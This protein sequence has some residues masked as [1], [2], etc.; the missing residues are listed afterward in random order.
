MTGALVSVFLSGC[1]GGQPAGEG[2]DEAPVNPSDGEGAS[3]KVS[4]CGHVDASGLNGGTVTAFNEQ[5]PEVEAQYVEIGAN[6]DQSRTQQVQRLEAQSTECDVFLMDVT[7]V[8]EFA[9]QDWLLDQTEIVDGIRDEVIPSP[10]E[11]AFYED[12]Y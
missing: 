12:K 2:P 3:G 9:T 10:L 6:T 1:G 5:N 7:W 11:T 8:S 4:M